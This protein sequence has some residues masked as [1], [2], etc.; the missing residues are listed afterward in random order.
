MINCGKT[1]VVTPFGGLL[2]S[3]AYAMS[4][5]LMYLHVPEKEW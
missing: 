3:A 4:E 2:H 5:E 1:E